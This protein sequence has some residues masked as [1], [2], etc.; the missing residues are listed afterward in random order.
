MANLVLGKNL[1]EWQRY[2]NDTIA[3]RNRITI[4]WNSRIRSSSKKL[5]QLGK[6]M[7]SAIHAEITKLMVG[8]YSPSVYNAMPL[9]QHEALANQLQSEVDN[10]NV[11]SRMEFGLETIRK[12]PKWIIVNNI[13]RD[14]A[15]R[16]IDQLTQN[17]STTSPSST[18]DTTTTP[19]ISNN[20]GS[21]PIVENGNNTPNQAGFGWMGYA[22]VGGV[23]ASL[24]L[25]SNRSK[26]KGM[27]KPLPVQL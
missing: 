25:A 21:V 26:N 27:N 2:L 24:L 5:R 15:K 8:V 18:P 9:A 11:G 19:P 23:A 12:A 3:E 1:L 14:L 16:A 17:N 13:K 6:N 7:Q 20:P 10:I 22:L 4:V